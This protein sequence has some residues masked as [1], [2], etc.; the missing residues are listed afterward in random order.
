MSAAYNMITVLG[1]TASGKTGFAAQLAHR[2]NGEIISA[3][4]RQVYRDMTIG[5]GKDY[6]DY[7]VEGQTVPYH[8]VDVIDSGQQYN[9]Y[10]YQ[11]DFIP[12]FES[13][14]ARAHLPILCGGTGLYL[15]AILKGYRLLDVPENQNIRQQLANKSMDELVELLKSLRKPHANT[16][17]EE[18][19][20]LLRAIEIEQYH[21]DHPNTD[22]YFPSINSLLIGVKFDRQSRRRR[23]T[24][25]LHQRLNEGMVDE[26]QKLLDRGIAP[27]TLITYG[28][29]YKYLTWYL[30]GK[31][32]YEQ[33]IV[34]LNTA[35]HQ[36]AKRQM[37]WF[38]RMER[39]GMRIHWLDGYAPMTDKLDKVLTLFENGQANESK[40]DTK[41]T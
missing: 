4:S 2:L 34:K 12:V 26:V 28:L 29:E 32:T 31:M 22:T 38:R 14:H 20:R 18:R 15:E 17:T 19:H 39:Q 40:D 8:L 16:D 21:H 25:R 7:A 27:Q 33:M 35:I 30:L 36:F 37:T 1:P 9:V 3:D 23:I 10:A 13:I 6:A 24:E 5:T 11:K 41:V